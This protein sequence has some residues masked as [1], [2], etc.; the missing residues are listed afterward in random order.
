VLDRFDLLRAK[1]ENVLDG[2]VMDI[3]KV[4]NSQ[5]MEVKRRAIGIAL[6]MVS[7]R[8]VEDVVLFLKKQLQGTMDA[9]FDKNLEY[10]Q[11]LIQSI[12]ACAIKF[13]EVAANV[14]YVLMDFLG[15]SNNPSA[16]DVIAF[17][18]EVVEKFPHLRAHITEK[19][20]STF[21]D[22]KS[23]KVFR[24]ALWIVGEYCEGG[25]EIKKALFEIR[26]VLGEIP[27]LASEQVSCDAECTMSSSRQR[28]LDEAEAAEENVNE[29]PAE[30]PKAVT[31]TRVLADGTYATETVYSSAA[32]AARLEKV[33]AATKPPLRALLLG[34]DFFTGSVLAAT[35]TKLVLRYAETASDDGAI[36]SIRAESILIMTSI[37]RVGQSKFSAVPIDEDS[38]ERIMN[39]IETLAE[40]QSSNV[41]ADVFL[42]DTKKAYSTMVKT[43]EKKA[44]A[45]KKE[46]KAHVVQ[47]DDLISFRQ[48]S[49][50]SAGGDLDDVSG[51]FR[52]ELMAVRPG[53]RTGYRGGHR[54]R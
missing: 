35:L 43:E 40:L 32:D 31:T 53:C 26:K 46:D 42:R 47:A 22:I 17:V 5:D 12:H 4:L 50:K 49:K 37:I 41:M 51:H 52:Q 10:R 39:C 48:L 25:A 2:M 34:G 13:S 16:V 1:H 36:N 38:Q 23:G 24:G 44:Q 14:V 11:L 29:K 21:G 18:R 8:N 9:D 27:I 54:A 28:L 45:K 7:S 20:V 19:L 15:D 6:E 30:Q 3:L 33:R